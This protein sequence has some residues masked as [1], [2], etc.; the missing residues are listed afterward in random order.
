MTV[1]GFFTAGT[2]RP[3]GS[4]RLAR[5]RMIESSRYLKAW[6]NAIAL[7]A[8]AARQGSHA[9]FPMRIHASVRLIFIM[10]HDPKARPDIDKLARPVLDAL[11][12]ARIIADDAIVVHL[13]A[14]KRR[15]E[16]GEQPGVDVLVGGE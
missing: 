11:K 6:R 2:P 4:K 1:V 9:L 15:P 5:G 10:P 3:Q 7:S 16:D 13:S 14:T 8:I 12:D